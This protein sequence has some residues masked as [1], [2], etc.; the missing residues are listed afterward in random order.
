MSE[1]LFL[2]PAL[3]GRRERNVLLP[4]FTRG[5]TL[6]RCQ[7]QMGGGRGYPHPSG[8]RG[9]GTPIL[10]K[11]GGYSHPYPYF[12]GWGSLHWDW[13]GYP[14]KIGWDTPTPCQDWMGVTP[15]QIATRWGISPIGTG[16]GS[17]WPRN[18]EN[19]EFGSYFFQT[20]KTQGILL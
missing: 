2:S 7:S 15:P 12:E 3:V 10:P 17:G 16:L 19:R 5:C 14:I 18:R 4:V 11:G 20:G 1:V 9:E 13:M 8:W 6:A